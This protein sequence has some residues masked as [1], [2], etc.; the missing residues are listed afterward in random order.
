MEVGV[1]LLLKKFLNFPGKVLVICFALVMVAGAFI[2]CSAVMLGHRAYAPFIVS[3]PS[4]APSYKDGELLLINK[5]DKN[6]ERG[7]VIVFSYPNNQSKLFI[8]RIIG[9]PSEKVDVQGGHV[10]INGVASTDMPVGENILGK[11]SISLK[12]DQY[13][14]LGDNQSVSSKDSRLM[15]PVNKSGIQGK[16]LFKF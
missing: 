4:M 8:A 13:Y 3:G 1:L 16:I 10:F 7:D 14:V 15:G 6:F 12:P 2:Y 9:L 5:L 11:S